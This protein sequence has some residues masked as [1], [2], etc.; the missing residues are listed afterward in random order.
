MAHCQL[1]TGTPVKPA[2]LI[3]ENVGSNPRNFCIF[4]AFDVLTCLFF[5]I[6]KEKL[7]KQ[8]KRERKEKKERKNKA[9]YRK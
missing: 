2:D 4:V 6:R 8:R 7:K 1:Q 3:V 9:E 5:A